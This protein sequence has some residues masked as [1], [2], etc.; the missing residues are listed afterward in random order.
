MSLSAHI[1]PHP[2]CGF[3]GVCEKRE[4]ERESGVGN[5]ELGTRIF[6][7]CKETALSRGRLLCVRVK[8]DFVTENIKVVLQ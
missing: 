7:E 1:V 5:W 4:K 2:L 8:S 6:Y 3:K